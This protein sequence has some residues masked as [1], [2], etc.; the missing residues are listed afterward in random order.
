VNLGNGN[1]AM[2]GLPRPRGVF[3]EKRSI[4]RQEDGGLPIEGVELEFALLV[5]GV[6]WG[7]NSSAGCGSEESNYKFERVRKGNRNLCLVT[8]L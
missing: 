5:G 3:C 1:L 4:W 6:Q 8:G 2:F 7:G